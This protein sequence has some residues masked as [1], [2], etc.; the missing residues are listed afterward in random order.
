ML[1]LSLIVIGILLRFAPHAPNFTP[2]AAIALF[3]GTYLNKKYALAI[4]LILMITSDIFIGMHNVILFT[5]GGF[6]LITLLGLWIK[7]HKN[8]LTVISMSLAS[9][10]LFYIV[11]N[12]GVWLMGWYPSN[13]KGLIDCYIMAVPFLRSFTLATIL[14][15]TVFFG[16]YELIARWVRDTKYSRVLLNN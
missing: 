2:I 16:V 10:I 13:L 8:T 7:K 3:S 4:P 5:W 9:S 15:T 6:I 14:Y 11:S 1:A 12:F